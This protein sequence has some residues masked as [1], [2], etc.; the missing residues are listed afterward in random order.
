MKYLLLS[1]IAV[2]LIGL[3][4]VATYGCCEMPDPEPHDPMR[5]IYSSTDDGVN[6]RDSVLNQDVEIIKKQREVRKARAKEQSDGV[7]VTG[8]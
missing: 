8:K 6:K 2:G 7:T 4:Q 5:C 3:S 1:L